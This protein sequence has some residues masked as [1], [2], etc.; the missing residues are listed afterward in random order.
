MP[1]HRKQLRVPQNHFEPLALLLT[2]PGDGWERW[3]RAIGSAEPS[4]SLYEVFRRAAA[5]A[6][7]PDGRQAVQLADVLS[8]LI[9]LS[10]DFPDS[11]S[12]VANVRQAAEA[13]GDA[14]FK[15]DAAAWASFTDR[16]LR[17]LTPRTA[18]WLTAKAGSVVA[19]TA[20]YFCESRIL[21]DLRPVF[22]RDAAQ[23]PMGFTIV[24]TMK[25]TLHGGPQD[26]EEVY[27]TLDASDLDALDE[28]ISRAREKYASLSRFVEQTQVRLLPTKAD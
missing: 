3:E 4:T 19:E 24:H 13:T 6:G 5:S 26:P 16:L 20:R 23:G 21:T 7:W 27:F 22:D 11:Q 28:T 12:L 9:R 14:R 8:S 2:A 10:E 25:V 18:A 15:A 17:L 1:A